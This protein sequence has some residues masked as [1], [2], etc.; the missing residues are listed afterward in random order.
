MNTALIINMVAC[1]VYFIARAYDINIF[2]FTWPIQVGTITYIA[3]MLKL[4]EEG[5]I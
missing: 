2:Q 3:V 5:V 1:L 4:Q